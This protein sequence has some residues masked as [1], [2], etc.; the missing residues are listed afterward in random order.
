MKS[1]FRTVLL[2][3]CAVL[4]IALLPWAVYVAL[5]YVIFSGWVKY[6][7]IYLSFIIEAALGTYL[8]VRQ[9]GKMKEKKSTSSKIIF[10]LVVVSFATYAVTAIIYL[11]QVLVSLI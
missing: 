1:N 3:I 10:G 11:A 7:A 4:Y 2:V 8:T 9:L 5:P 6:L